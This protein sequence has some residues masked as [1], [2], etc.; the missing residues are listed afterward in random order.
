MLYRL[1]GITFSQILKND[2]VLTLL[3]I[4]QRSKV[5]HKLK[6]KYEK[7]LAKKKQ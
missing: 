4:V 2:S 6:R 7:R 3:E 5:L 1:L